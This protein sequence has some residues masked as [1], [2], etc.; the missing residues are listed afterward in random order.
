MEYINSRLAD[1]IMDD[2]ISLSSESEKEIDFWINYKNQT[3]IAETLNLDKYYID[4]E[5]KLKIKKLRKVRLEDMKSMEINFKYCYS[6]VVWAY[7]KISTLQ[8]IIK[9]LNKEINKAKQDS[10]SANNYINTILLSNK[11]K[12]KN[13]KMAVKL[14]CQ[15]N[16]DFRLEKIQEVYNKELEYLNQQYQEQRLEFIRKDMFIYKLCKCIIDQ[17]YLLENIKKYFRR[18]LGL[19]RI[20]SFSEYRNAVLL[21]FDEKNM[22]KG[23]QPE[24]KNESIKSGLSGAAPDSILLHEI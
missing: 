13:D 21:Q 8:N 15:Q 24:H 5:I 18:K 9:S 11:Q 1:E 12:N 23:N 19:K 7:D 14:Q 16:F 4:D 17:E 6:E 22:K 10:Q 3:D 20:K 2:N